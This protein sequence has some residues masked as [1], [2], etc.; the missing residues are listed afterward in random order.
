MGCGKNK[1]KEN[2][3]VY[4]LNNRRIICYDSSKTQ[5]PG[6][7]FCSVHF[8]FFPPGCFSSESRLAPFLSF[9]AFVF[10]SSG[11]IVYQ[12]IY[13]SQ[14]KPLSLLDYAVC[15]FLWSARPAFYRPPIT[16]PLINLLLRL[17]LRLRCRTVVNAWG[18]F[19]ARFQPIFQPV[20]RTGRTRLLVY[21]LFV[22]LLSRSPRRMDGCGL[23]GPYTG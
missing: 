1:K 18:R 5:N 7:G 20:S 2:F 4:S 17:R 8:F 21:L 11:P 22:C 16:F 19:P 13:R 15:P 3:G 9:P 10:V 14:Q 23:E 6:H 12:W